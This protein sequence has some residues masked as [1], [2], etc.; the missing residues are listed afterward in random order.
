MDERAAIK[1]AALRR[2]R[3]ECPGAREAVKELYDNERWHFYWQRNT[4]DRTTNRSLAIARAT[5]DGGK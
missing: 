2:A 4:S 1:T 5:I 3:R